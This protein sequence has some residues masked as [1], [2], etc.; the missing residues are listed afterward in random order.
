LAL[1]PFLMLYTRR[2]SS[3]DVVQA[4]ELSRRPDL[5]RLPEMLSV[6]VLMVLIFVVRRNRVER[7]DPLLLMIAAFALMPIAVFNQ[8]II[9]GHSLQPLHYEMFAANYSALIPVVLIIALTRKYP[10]ALRW[11]ISRRGLVW[12]AIIAFEWGGYETLV[13]SRRSMEFDRRLDDG[14][15]VALRLKQL[16]MNA[17]TGPEEATVLSSD[18]IV[19][20]VLPTTAPQAV[21]WAPHL[22]VF[23]GASAAT[24]KER[25]YQYLYYTGVGPD[26]LRE[27]LTNEH[28]YGFAVGLFGF[29]RT[30]KGLSINPRPITMDELE[31]ELRRYARYCASFDQSRGGQPRLTWLVVSADGAPDLANLDRW[32]VRDAGERVGNFTLYRVSLRESN[33]DQRDWRR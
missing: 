1:V 15:A 18:L 19:A 13:A 28:E 3:M 25:F 31:D 5:F 20:D 32:Y 16:A 22:L 17:S 11:T 7:N 12:L 29:E 30:I 8:Q 9:T 21:L 23:S 6:L 27:I 10:G 4:L 24:A 2:A 14:R 33:G 26:R